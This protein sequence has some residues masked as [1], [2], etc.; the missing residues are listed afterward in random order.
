ME[1]CAFASSEHFTRCRTAT[2]GNFRDETYSK[3]YIMLNI[4]HREYEEDGNL[5][6][7]NNV[8]Y[9]RLTACIANIREL[10]PN[11]LY[12]HAYTNWYAVEFH[13]LPKYLL[14]FDCM[15]G[16]IEH[17]ILLESSMLIYLRPGFYNRLD[18]DWIPTFLRFLDVCDRNSFERCSYS[19]YANSGYELPRPFY[20]KGFNLYDLYEIT[21]EE[22][23]FRKFP[24]LM[25]L[26]SYINDHH[27][28]VNTRYHQKIVDT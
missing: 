16:T 25:V 19:P 23:P 5:K 22:H 14:Y 4:I 10:P 26:G 28:C 3:E 6:I 1:L 18:G 27:Y 21:L 12:L 17:N 15:A 11:L 8:V 2:L 7:Y 9:L 13:V 20:E 24:E